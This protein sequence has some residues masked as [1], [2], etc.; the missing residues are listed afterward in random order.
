[1]VVW[2]PDGEKLASGDMNGEIAIWD[3]KTGE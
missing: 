1:M 2:S 3:P